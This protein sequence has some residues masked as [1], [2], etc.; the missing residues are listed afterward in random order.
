MSKAKI[1]IVGITRG[2]VLPGSTHR[3]T[4]TNYPECIF[5]I[6]SK[7]KK[8]KMF[9]IVTYKDPEKKQMYSYGTVV[10]IANEAPLA[11]SQDVFSGL[12]GSTSSVNRSDWRLIVMGVERFKILSVS[13]DSGVSYASVQILKDTDSKISDSQIEELREIGLKY[14]KSTQNTDVSG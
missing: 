1:P 2:V 5:Y 6:V 13:E 14:L 8:M 7:G 9:G 4:I 3:I 12:F 11:R 10:G